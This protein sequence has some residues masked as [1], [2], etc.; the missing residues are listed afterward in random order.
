MRKWA[1]MTWAQIQALDREQ[2]LF[3]MPIGSIEQHGLHLP[4][5]TDYLIM[6]RMM[7]DL[8][9]REDVSFEIV[10]L[11]VLQFGL[12]EEHVYFPGT[13]VL[14]QQEIYK[15]HPELFENP[16]GRDVHAGEFET[17]LMLYLFLE[18]VDTSVPRERWT[19]CNVAASSLPTGWL[20]QECSSIGVIG[21][22]ALATAEKGRKYFEMAC[23]WQLGKLRTFMGQ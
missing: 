5:G 15:S 12:N 10:V 21:D 11:P 9:G 6:E 3:V 19:D 23:E 16:V 22:G 14:N 7:D 18:L 8:L 1:E 2:T 20:S 4:V 13:V 17:F